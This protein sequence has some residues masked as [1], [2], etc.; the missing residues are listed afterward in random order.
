[1]SDTEEREQTGE[2]QT[3]DAERQRRQEDLN[4]KLLAAAKAGNN[5]EVIQHISDGAEITSSDGGQT[6]LHISAKEGH[7]DVMRTFITHKLDIN[8]KGGYYQDTPLMYAADYGHLSCVQLLLAHGADPDLRSRDGSTALMDA[9]SRDYPEIIAELL[10]TGADDQIKDEDGKN[11]LKHAKQRGSQDAMRMFTA[12]K[13]KSID[14]EMMTAAEYGKARLVTGLIIAGADV[15]TRNDR[16]ERGLDLAVRFGHRDVVQT[17]LDHDLGGYSSREECLRQCD[18]NKERNKKLVAAAES[19]DN[20]SVTRLLQEGAEI[21]SRD[22]K[23]NTG[24]H[25]SALTGHKDVMETFITHQV[26]INARGQYQRTALMRAAVWGKLSCVQLLLAHGADTDLR[27]EDG[28]TALIHA[29]SKSYPDPD[30]IAELLTHGADD[31]IADNLGQNALTHAEKLRSQDAFRM[32]TAWKKKIIDQ[33]M[34]TAAADGIWRLVTGLLIAGADV[35]TRNDRGETVLDLAQRAGDRAG[36]QTL[37]DHGLSGYSREECLRQCQKNMDLVAAAQSG[38]NESVIRLLQDG[39]D[40]TSRNRDGDTGLHL[41][42]SR[43]HRDVIQTFIT[44]RVDVNIRGNNQCTALMKAVIRNYPDII[45]ELLSHGADDQIQDED[46]KNALTHAENNNS[47]D[48]VKVLKARKENPDKLN[49]EI[50]TEAKKEDCNWKLVKGL[51]SHHPGIDHLNKKGESALRLAWDAENTKLV[52]ILLD[53]GAQ[54]NLQNAKGETSLK[55]EQYVE[56]NDVQKREQVIDLMIEND[57]KR[58]PTSLDDSQFRIKKEI[59]KL[60]PSSCNLRDCLKSVS[61]NFPWSNGKYKVM[62]ALSF[63]LQ[64]IRGTLF[65]GWDVYTDIQFTLEMYRQSNRNFVE[66][67][68]KCKNTFEITFD[69]A[70]ETCKMHFDK[71]ACLESIAQVDK[72]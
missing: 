48:A 55:I 26:D 59:K 25:I 62:L 49:K 29:A 27:D 56:K 3:D 36:V 20:E 58:N 61:E 54:I 57:W 5:E 18:E 65:Y 46:G 67:I 8:I 12:W 10:R 43:G 69:I 44:Q 14:Q 2:S 1:M 38:D 39:A 22:S 16:G 11:A 53:K 50:V 41:S 21:T 23:G 32:L 24:L 51:I 15:N 37:L 64:V 60:V 71:I 63:I 66:D 40:I 7:K 34:M 42:A 4:K 52:K 47:Q 72:K 17:L 19:G 70:I 33:E 6:G 35:K 31:Q 68:S 28:G 9:A 45:A 13:E 30:I